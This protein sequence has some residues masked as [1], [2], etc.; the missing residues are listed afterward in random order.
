MS[1]IDAASLWKRLAQAGLV[2][3][4]P[5]ADADAESPWF[6]RTMLG[7]AGWIGAVFLL[8]FVGTAFTLIMKSAGAS[9]VL[10]ALTCAGATVLYRVKPKGDFINQFAF[11][12]SLAGQALVCF[13]LGQMM[14]SEISAVAILV[15]LVEVI[16]F[17][18]IPNF[19]HR[20]W[21]A[22]AGASAFTI[23]LNMSGFYFYTQ[24]IVFA[25]FSWVWVNEFN[26]PERS[27]QMR[28]LGYGLVLLV[29]SNLAAGSS[30]EMLSTEWMFRD[31]SSPIGGVFAWWIGSALVGA[32]A[33]WVIWK[34]LERQGVGLS[35]PSGR[36][37][38]AGAILVALVSLKAPGIGV[39]VT[40]L[41]L[42]FANGNRVLA[43][44]GIL[45]LVGY[46]S[47][48]YYSL[49]A[50]LLQKSA[51]L[52]CTGIVLIVARLA[53]KRRWPGEKAAG[54]A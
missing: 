25:A 7:I 30:A 50:T 38:L 17:L 41:L 12:V 36:A 4:E 18:L 37:G 34:L 27:A 45:S 13:G 19:L 21:T 40:I 28:A 3:G 49:Q 5:P 46:W 8:G 33:I 43:G 14:T 39:T 2:E 54:H 9:A 22:L 10:G 32:I 1:G 51:L 15:A 20:V 42:G 6:V 24:A 31:R 23:A 47:Y 53:L 52:F 11:A 29:I 48:Y 16:L 35:S 44:L 26:F